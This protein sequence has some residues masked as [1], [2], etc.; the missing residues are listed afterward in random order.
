MSKGKIIRNGEGN[1]YD[2]NIDGKRLK[3]KSG[4]IM[5]LMSDGQWR[6]FEEIA[7]ALNMPAGSSPS[8]SASLREFRRE[9]WGYMQV[10]KRRRATY[11]GLWEYRVLPPTTLK[12]E[13]KQQ[14]LDF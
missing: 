11:S 4:R 13:L 7:E 9:K 8:I 6:V 2:E 14:L 10:E 12:K 3:T 5:Q 1:G